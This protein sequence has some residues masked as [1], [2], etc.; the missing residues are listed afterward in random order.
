METWVVILIVVF[1]I[2]IIAI[3]IIW[4]FV[5]RGNVPANALKYGD[6]V[7]VNMKNEVSDRD[8][9]MIPCG[10]KFIDTSTC[11]N[12]VVVVTSSVTAPSN[13]VKSWTFNSTTKKK[14]EPVLYGDDVIITSGTGGNLDICGMTNNVESCGDNIGISTG[15]GHLTIRK[16][17]KLTDTTDTS[18]FVIKNTNLSILNKTSNIRLSIC[19][20]VDD[21]SLCSDSTDTSCAFNV[22]LRTA[23]SNNV[24]S[25]SDI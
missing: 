17:Q 5:F 9:P 4:V 24:W 21:C 14:G 18:N 10:I 15:V 11:K 13:T 8:G 16:R 2:I 12:N 25:I 20:S 7:S 19:G 3:I 23:D 6:I 22:T 1:L